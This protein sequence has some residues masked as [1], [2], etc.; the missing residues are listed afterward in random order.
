MK[1][2]QNRAI[3]LQPDNQDDTILEDNSTFTMPTSPHLFSALV[4]LV[5]CSTSV[6]SFAP[7]TLRAARNVHLGVGQGVPESAPLLFD[8]N[9]L[10]D[11]QQALLTLEK[12]VKEG[13][14][15]LSLSEVKDLDGRFH[16]ITEDMK[17]NEHKKPERP[18]QTGAPSIRVPAVAVPPPPA[19]MQTAVAAPSSSVGGALDTSEEGPAYDGRG[20]MGQPLG[21]SSTYVLPGME[22]MSPEEYR[23][24]L[25]ESVS[26]RQ[27][28][29]R[30][31]GVTGNRATWDYLNGL[32]GETGV[33]KKPFS[34]EK[35]NQ[36]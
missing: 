24:A 17:L 16:R 31:T 29:R 34:V 26:E 5:L 32:T 10:D 18:P 22:E 33:L 20:G 1:V 14:G 15:S 35:K 23:K 9:L 7:R 36:D 27:R 11:I 6:F 3:F 19:Q 12:R 25:Q 2:L 4:A 21:T 30:E 28:K 8:E 13:P